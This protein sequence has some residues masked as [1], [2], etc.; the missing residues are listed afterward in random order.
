MKDIMAPKKGNW[1]S[2]YKN[3]Y[4]NN[5]VCEERRGKNEIMQVFL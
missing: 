2:C 5:G 1:I 4:T 3:F